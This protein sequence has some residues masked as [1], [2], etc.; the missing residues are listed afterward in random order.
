MK[1]PKPKLNRKKRS[2]RSRA[3][4]AAGTAPKP[5]AKRKRKVVSPTGQVKLKVP[6]TGWPSPTQPL[7]EL[8][9]IPTRPMF[10]APRHSYF[11]GGG[12]AMPAGFLPDGFVLASKP[13]PAEY[14]AAE[15]RSY[16][17][18]PEGAFVRCVRYELK[19]D[20]E[21]CTEKPSSDCGSVEMPFIEAGDFFL[22]LQS[23]GENVLSVRCVCNSNLLRIGKRGKAT[24]SKCGLV[25]LAP[26]ERV[27]LPIVTSTG[28]KDY[29]S[30]DAVKLPRDR[31]R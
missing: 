31:T 30:C 7:P 23:D 29:F 6:A 19:P 11:L 14:R 10:D 20:A 21:Q 5:A 15:F 2:V 9:K 13:K 28:M 1:K 4:K 26:T 24:C 8:E 25:Y 16:R 27:G 17:T 18:F 22:L 3:R 12:V